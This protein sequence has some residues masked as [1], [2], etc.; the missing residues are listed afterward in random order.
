MP[1]MVGTQS[2]PLT[3]QGR[4]ACF[5]ALRHRRQP[6]GI[7]EDYAIIRR[8]LRRPPWL[9][10]RS[11]PRPGAFTCLPTR[12]SPP[13]GCWSNSNRFAEALEILRPLAPDHPNQTDVR[14]LLGLAAVR[15][16]QDAR[17]PDDEQREALLDEAIAAFRSIL[18]RTAR[19][20]AR[21]PWNWAWPSISRRRIT[22]PASISNG[23]WW[24][25]RRRPLVANVT[26]LIKGHSGPAPLGRVVRLLH[27]PGYE[28]QRGIRRGVHLYQ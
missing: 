23:P 25:S 14:F 2:A 20:G 26:R 19:I 18:I 10:P 5:H 24:G 7:A 28:Y 9:M 8:P 27:C 11:R 4:C 12:A 22:W 15:G 1:Q 16:S 3:L 17:A 21:A 13:R 6:A